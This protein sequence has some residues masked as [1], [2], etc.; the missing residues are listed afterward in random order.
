M[1]MGPGLTGH[2]TSKKKLI[3]DF[4]I[5]FHLKKNYY[6]NLKKKITEH[7]HKVHFFTESSII[8]SGAASLFIIRSHREL[9]RWLDIADY[10]SYEICLGNTG[11]LLG[12]GCLPLQGLR[13]L[14]W[15][16]EQVGMVG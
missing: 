1:H 15:G 5:K 14:E 3:S 10:L 4:Y 12:T 11:P 8:I 6:L 13:C 2:L 16:T 9:L 7:I